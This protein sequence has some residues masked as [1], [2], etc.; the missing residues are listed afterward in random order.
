M[1]FFLSFFILIAKM[2]TI[3]LYD[4]PNTFIGWGKKEN[5]HRKQNSVW[6]G[7]RLKFKI[8]CKAIN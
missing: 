4:L 1:D 6:I 3:F 5:K 7:Y 2:K 8:R